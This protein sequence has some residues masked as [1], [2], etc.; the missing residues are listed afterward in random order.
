MR[1]IISRGVPVG[2]TK[3]CHAVTLKPGKP[4]SSKAGSSGASDERLRPVTASALSLPVLTC[5]SEA[6][7]LPNT[8]CVSPASTAVAAGGKWLNQADRLCGIVLAECATSGQS[9]ND[10]KSTRR[11]K[12]LH[13]LVLVS[14]CA[15]PV[16]WSRVRLRTIRQS[17]RKRTLRRKLNWTR[18]NI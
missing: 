14:H 11:E 3:L 17:V 4:D 12:V 1:A 6:A 10:K 7:T 15:L 18:C 16:G 13:Q 9:P 2:A 5:C 8:S